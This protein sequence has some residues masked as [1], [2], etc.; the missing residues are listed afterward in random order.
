MRHVGIEIKVRP[1][2]H[3]VYSISQYCDI[4]DGLGKE[5]LDRVA[6]PL[7]RGVVKDIK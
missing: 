3:P 6:R 4:W 1:T 7:I 2:G 5:L